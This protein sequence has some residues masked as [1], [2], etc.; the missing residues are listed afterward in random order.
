MVGVGGRVDAIVGEI[1]EEK[2][3]RRARV[4]RNY[5]VLRRSTPSYC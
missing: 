4:V 2:K 5:R 1:T 3:R